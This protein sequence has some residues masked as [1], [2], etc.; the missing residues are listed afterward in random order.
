MVRGFA[1]FVV[2]LCKDVCPKYCMLLWTVYEYNNRMNIICMLFRFLLVVYVKISYIA[3]HVMRKGI[4]QA[5]C[6]IL[7]TVQ[8][9]LVP[10][11]QLL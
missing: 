11:V 10:K 2:I 3:S 1:T 4:F 8:H 7:T 5:R 9:A 6:G